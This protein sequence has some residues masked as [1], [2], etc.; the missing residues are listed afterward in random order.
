MLYNFKNPL[1]RCLSR[2]TPTI[3][4]V[5]QYLR[6]W[7]N[8]VWHCIKHAVIAVQRKQPWRAIFELEQIRNRTIELRGLREALETKRF[9]HVD[10]MSKGFLTEL[11]RTL[12]MSLTDIDI[13]NALQAAT[14]CFFQEAQHF[15]EMLDF[16]L[17][18]RFEAKI[19]VYLELFKTDTDT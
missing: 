14:V 17:A 13:M 6:N 12:V 8:T 3:L 10:Q 4:F 2:F 15:D 16:K 5:N 11:E 7:K 19:K 9:R 1:K 18:E